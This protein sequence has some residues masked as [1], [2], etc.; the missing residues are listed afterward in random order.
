M[1]N[2]KKIFIW[3]VGGHGRT[4]LDIFNKGKKYKVAYF[5]DDNPALKGKII[6]GVKVIGGQE[7]L[8]DMKK[9][10]INSGIAGI[11]DCKKRCEI[12]RIMKQSGFSFVNAIDP[13]AIISKTAKIGEGVTIWPGAVINTNAVV[14]DNVII[15]E[16]ATISHDDVIGFG[17]HIAAG[18]NL[19]G[20]LKIGEKTLIGV[21]AVIICKKIGSNSVIG[22]GSVVANDIGDNVVAIGFPARVVGKRN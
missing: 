21:G 5:V 17:S 18:V 1:K 11:G 15:N 20:G 4:L 19:I 6:Q 12:F 14:G 8:A 22:A 16:T 10:G 2:P 3:G 13:S 9:N 7:A